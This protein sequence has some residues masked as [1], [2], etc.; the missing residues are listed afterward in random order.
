[1]AEC[2]LSA[3]VGRGISTDLR[4]KMYQSPRMTVAILAGLADKLWSMPIS[5]D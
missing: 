5:L 1:V 2:G 3:L 4:V